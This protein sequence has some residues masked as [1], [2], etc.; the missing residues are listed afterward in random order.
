MHL[1][2]D[3]YMYVSK[4]GRTPS[5]GFPLQCVSRWDVW[6]ISQLYECVYIGSLLVE[7]KHKE[8]TV[9]NFCLHPPIPHPPLMSRLVQQN[10]ISLAPACW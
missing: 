4:R 8:Y 2:A 10:T 5:A 9:I 6:G 7:H 3:V 1:R